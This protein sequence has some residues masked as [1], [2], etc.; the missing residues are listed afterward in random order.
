MLEALLGTK[1][2]ELTLQYLLVFNE[3][4]ARE[5]AKYFDVSLPSIQNQLQH[6]EANGLALSKMSGRTK[7]YFLN[8]RYAFL[9]ELTALLV[10]ARSYYKPELKEK[11]E[12]QRKRPRRVGKP[13]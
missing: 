5:I 12:M 9:E 8:P 13:L 3:G 7:V 11:F 10:K 1:N 6:F 2:R 4:Y